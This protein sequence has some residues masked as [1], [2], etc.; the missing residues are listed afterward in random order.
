MTDRCPA[1]GV[2]TLIS[3]II[4]SQQSLEGKSVRVVGRVD[5]HDIH[6]NIVMLSEPNKQNCQIR[7]DIHLTDTDQ[8]VK[9]SL[10][11]LIGELE[12]DDAT[13][14]ITLKPRVA[15]SVGR[16]DYTLYC[17]SVEVLR[18]FDEICTQG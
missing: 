8:Y 18:K 1:Y 6:T 13:G 2:P 3:E 14:E 7:V 16:M 17:R 9:G 10:V 4:S 11:M 5:Q 15:R 12:K